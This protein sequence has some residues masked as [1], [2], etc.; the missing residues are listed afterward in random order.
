[1]S[2]ILTN[3]SAKTLTNA[4]EENLAEFFALFQN[5]PQAE[6][7]MSP[8]LIWTMTGYPFPLFNGVL[9]ARLNPEQVNETIEAAMA[10]AQSKEAPILWWTGPATRPANL[11]AT[12]VGHGFA[13]IG[14]PPGM[15]MDLKA[16]PANTPAPAGL[17]IEQVDTD[18]VLKLW[19]QIFEAGFG[20]PEFISN[21]YYS[22][23]ASQGLAADQPLRNYIGRL[24]GEAVGIS[25][26]LLAAGVAGIYNV[27]T[28]P[29][30]QRQGIGSAMSL[31]PLHEAR[32][33]GYR[34]AV[35]Q[36]SDVGV[37]VYR[38]LG[39]QEY[40]QLEQYMWPVVEG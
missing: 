4:I 6:I 40:C 31:H 37:G 12:L 14:G 15:A 7:E 33:M 39:F 21:A 29:S 35:L 18:D 34:A 2:E 13:P 16:L 5:W 24:N 25:S 30:A 27:A 1:M 22:F 8:Q 23:M 3:L 38:K 28:L 17:T 20:F 36:S 19:A 11:G 32:L 26:L 9:Q 10:R